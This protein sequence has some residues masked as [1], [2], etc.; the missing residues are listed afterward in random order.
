MPEGIGATRSIVRSVMGILTLSSPPCVVAVLSSTCKG[1]RTALRAL[2]E[3]LKED[4]KKVVYDVIHARNANGR[5][6]WHIGMD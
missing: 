3:L 1:L 5:P 4:H 6:R 2:R